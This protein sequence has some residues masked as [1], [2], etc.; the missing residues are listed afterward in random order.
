MSSERLLDVAVI[1]AGMAGLKVASE[2]Q[3]Q[4]QAVKVFEKARGTGGRM[5]S[6]RFNT[7]L[8]LQLSF[9]L[10]CASFTA[11]SSEFRQQVMEWC[12]LGKA[13]YWLDAEDGEQFVAVPRNSAITRHMSGS[14]DCCFATRITRIQKDGVWHLYEQ[15]DNGK[16]RLLALAR[17]LVITAPPQQATDLLPVGVFSSLFSEVIVSPQWVMMVHVSNLPADAQSRYLK[18]SSAIEVISTETDKPGRDTQVVGDILMVQASAE[19]SAQRLE[20]KAQQVFYE[21]KQELEQ[22]LSGSLEVQDFYIHRW[23]YSQTKL[24]ND[25][26]LNDTNAIDYWWHDSGVAI[27]A[28]YTCRRASGV[29]AAWLAGKSLAQWLCTKELNNKLVGCN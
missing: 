13:E 10:G 16:E 4:G 27:A 6:K 2:L 17:T 3:Q 29:E 24:A 22:V 28:D 11:H 1:G 15:A 5:S 14:V 23:L 12:D 18:P 25:P 21:L 26:P 9:D 20:L 8:G 7:Q 19:W